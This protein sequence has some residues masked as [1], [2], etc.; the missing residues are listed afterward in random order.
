MGDD[1][2]CAVCGAETGSVIHVGIGEDDDDGD[3]CCS[4]ICAAAYTTGVACEQAR[5]GLTLGLAEWKANAA[6]LEG[7]LAS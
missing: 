4:W 7:L 1:V 6:E 5:L 3:W 2:I